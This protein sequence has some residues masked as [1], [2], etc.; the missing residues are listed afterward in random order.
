MF[1]HASPVALVAAR[2]TRARDRT[3]LRRASLPRPEPRGSVGPWVHGPVGPWDRGSVGPWV[4][5][6]MGPWVRGTV[7]PWVRGP[8]GPWVRGPVG[9]WVRGS[10]GPWVRGSVGPW[11]RG[12][13]WV[14]PWVRGSVGPWVRGSVG[15]WVRG[16]VGPWAVGPWVRGSVGPW[17]REPGECTGCRM[18]PRSPVAAGATIHPPTIHGGRA[19]RGS[20]KMRL[21]ANATGACSPMPANHPSTNMFRHMGIR[22]HGTCGHPL[23]A[24]R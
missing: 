19:D 14:G 2:R 18:I 16:S 9:P 22:L 20:V 10:V 5:G 15:P 1:G 6:P 4:R 12:P 3:T 17:V 13:P 24:G 11:V 7:G 8:V 21:A 23:I